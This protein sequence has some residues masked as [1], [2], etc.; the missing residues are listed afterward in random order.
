MPLY[1]LN[2]HPIVYADFDRSYQLIWPP[3]SDLYLQSYGN[4][5]CTSPNEIRVRLRSIMNFLIERFDILVREL[6]SASFFMFVHLNNDELT[7]LYND[8]IAGYQIEHENITRHEVALQQRVYKVILEQFVKFPLT[9]QNFIEVEIQANALDYT[10]RLETL[11]YIG[12]KIFNVIDWIADNTFFPGSLEIGIIENGEFG[13]SEDLRYRHIHEFNLTDFHRHEVN[14]VLR[15]IVLDLTAAIHDAFNVD[16][17]SALGSILYDNLIGDYSYM[18]LLPHINDIANEIN[19]N[20][21]QLRSFFNGLTLT[22]DNALTI[23]DSFLRS[24]ENTRFLYRPIL[25]LNINGAIVHKLSRVKLNESITTLTSNAIPYGHSPAEWK[26][27]R[28][29]RRFEGRIMNTQ[30]NVLQAPLCNLLHVYGLMFDQSMKSLRTMVPSRNLNIEREPGE[31]DIIFLKEHNNGS[32]LTV[33]VCE[34]KNNRF[35]SDMLSWER[36]Y[37]NFVQSYEPQLSRKLYWAQQN[38]NE[39]LVH[40]EI[41]KALEPGTL[42][43]K[44]TVVLGLFLINAPTLYMY[45]GVFDVYTVT[46][47]EEFLIGDF[48]RGT[49]ALENAETGNIVYVNY[50]YYRN[51][52]ALPK[53]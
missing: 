6:P 19:C 20:P 46:S 5:W 44:N 8:Q 49:F 53:I 11:L 48:I 40:F 30:D 38:I 33:F 21:N 7:H 52:R 27:Q 13:I 39:L 15:N 16:Y 9:H 42:T 29:Y 34:C 43:N 14:V 18:N 10:E 36:D 17:G 22:I 50:P 51:L 47:F 35:R 23:E 25:Q 45:D 31:I 41:L 37:S 24:Q 32:D 28:P 12:S 3:L 1:T 2:H 26:S 4:E